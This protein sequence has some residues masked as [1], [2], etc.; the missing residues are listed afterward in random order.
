MAFCAIGSPY[1]QTPPVFITYPN[2]PLSPCFSCD[3]FATSFR[4]QQ[5]TPSCRTKGRNSRRTSAGSTFPTSLFR[6]PGTRAWETI[7][8]SVDQRQKTAEALRSATKVSGGC[9]VH[10]CFSGKQ[11]QRRNLSTVVETGP[12]RIMTHTCSVVGSDD[13]AYRRLA[14]CFW[15]S[16]VRL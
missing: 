3:V 12:R 14:R 5:G 1:F 2:R 11:V 6:G 16:S 10:W 8:T 13:G 15:C 9:C 7:Q 4:C